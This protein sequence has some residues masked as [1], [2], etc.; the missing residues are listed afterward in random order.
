MSSV[1]TVETVHTITL[2]PYPPPH[3]QQNAASNNS[4]VQVIRVTDAMARELLQLL[5]K[6]QI[7][8]IEGE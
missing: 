3:P 7:G 4:A 1:I 2:P 6:L 8:T 5:S